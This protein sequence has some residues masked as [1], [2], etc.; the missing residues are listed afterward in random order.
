MLRPDDVIRFINLPNP[1]SPT[2]A[3]GS[4]KPLTEMSTRNFPGG[5]READNATAICEPTV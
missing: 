2:V 5:A 4:P 1:S 3:L